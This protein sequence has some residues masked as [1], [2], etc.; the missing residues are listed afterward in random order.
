MKLKVKNIGLSTGG[1]LIAILNK[2][3]AINLDLF[4][5]DRVRLKKNNKILSAVIDIAEDHQIIPGYIGLF[6]EVVKKLKTHNNEILNVALQKRPASIKIIKRKLKDEKLNSQDYN[7]IVKDIV[8]NRLSDTE[9]TYFVS[10]CYTRGMTLD[11]SAYLTRALVKNGSQLKLNK[12]P[13]LDK[14]SI[15]GIA[16]NR[17]TPIVVSIIA[18]AGFTIPKTSSRAITSAAGTADTMEVLASVSHPIKKIYSIVK[19]TNACLV[20]GGALDLA[21]ADDKLIKIEHP[22]SLDPK[23]ILL[24]SIMAKKKAVNATHVIVDIPYG[25]EAKISK[26]V[27]AKDLQKKF[28]Q[29]G[30]KLGMKVKAVITKGDQPIGKGI[31]PVLEAMDV[32]EVLQGSGP[33]DLRKKSLFLANELF[34]MVNHKPEASKILDS[35]L[36]YKKFLEIIK[37]QGGKKPKLTL[38]SFKYNL[39]TTKAGKVSYIDNKEINHIARIAGAPN[40]KK[41]GI[42]LH[43]RLNSKV[44]K[45]QSILTIYAENKSKLNFAIEALR[46]SEVVKIK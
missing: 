18:A 35:G 8:A 30:K 44:K 43:V 19:K 33:Q 16:G 34:K 14:H 2:E 32:L 27:N 46:D 40:N 41:A 24:S 22:L 12:K 38:A 29:L 4:A 15:G 6:Q 3:D 39:K 45:S 26:L 13:I 10:A 37:A 20:W 28:T 25:K 9:I 23:G 17:T 36:A 5:L 7:Q 11:E 21:S 42:Y 1:P 31:G